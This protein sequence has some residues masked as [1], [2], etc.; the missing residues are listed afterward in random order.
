MQFQ[1]LSQFSDFEQ[2]QDHHKQGGRGC[3]VFSY[4]DQI[5]VNP[6]GFKLADHLFATS[7]QS[8]L[9]LSRELSRESNRYRSQHLLLAFMEYPDDQVTNDKIRKFWQDYD[10]AALFFV[11]MVNIS[12]KGSLKSTIDRINHFFEKQDYLVYTSFEHNELFIFCKGRRFDQY[13]QC[14]MNLNYSVVENIPNYVQDTITICGFGKEAEEVDEETFDAYIGL[15]TNNYEQASAFL[16]QFQDE[17]NGRKWLLGRNDVAALLIDSNLKQLYGVYQ[18]CLTKERKAE[19]KNGEEKKNWILT[20]NLSVLITPVNEDSLNG[21]TS[22]VLD[23]KIEQFFPEEK[24][25]AKVDELEAAYDKACKVLSINIDKVFLRIL[26]NIKNMLCDCQTIQ[27]AKDL[28]ACLLPQFWDFI[29]YMIIC[30]ERIRE[31]RQIVM[32]HGFINTFYLNVSILIN[33]TVH[34]DRQF[35]QIPHCEGSSFEMPSKIIAYYMIMSRCIAS[36]LKDEENVF[37]GIMLSPKLVDELEVE[38]PLICQET[39]PDQLISINISEKMMYQPLRTVTILAHEIAHYVGNQIRRRDVRW[40][41]IFSY[42]INQTLQNVL[43][44]YRVQLYSDC[45]ET[46]GDVLSAKKL[47]E[48]SDRMCNELFPVPKKTEDTYK[49]KIRDSI[50]KIPRRLLQGRSVQISNELLFPK[51]SVPLFEKA[52]R[53][54]ISTRI[55]SL[56]LEDNDCVKQML[57]AYGEECF[58][59]TLGQFTRNY[60]QTVKRAADNKRRYAP[61]EGSI[62][63]VLLSG[64]SK[65]VPPLAHDFACKV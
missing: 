48:F 34:S 65:G 42:Y 46:L 26:H 8:T 56:N 55:N 9:Q 25:T 13:S 29:N 6:C 40:R 31:K 23:Q 62:P 16:N 36:I 5:T 64:V 41:C 58:I 1:N 4:F 28:I 20:V 49:W 53:C 22:L 33:S 3:R 2:F 24:L 14:V 15:G 44:E 63:P 60:T 10:Q 45:T 37:Y 59:F 61:G 7:Y 38:S 30:C 47:K 35:I 11:T 39:E 52:L 18:K 19:D 32:L 17:S 54:S 21:T 12:S 57:K 43:E 27:M 50:I 51:N